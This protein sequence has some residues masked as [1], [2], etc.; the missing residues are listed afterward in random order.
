MSDSLHPHGPEHAR[1]LCP[2]DSPGKDT[3]VGAMPSSKGSSPPKDRTCVSY[4]SCTGRLVLHHEHHLGSPT[5]ISWVGLNRREVRVGFW[6]EVWSQTKWPKAG[7]YSER[8]KMWT[9]AQEEF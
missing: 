5:E 1:L 2:W 9:T 8:H 4:V 7:S 6:L 3:G